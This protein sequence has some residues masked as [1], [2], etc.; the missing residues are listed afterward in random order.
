[1]KSTN[2][3]SSGPAEWMERRAGAEGNPSGPSPRRTQKRGRVSPA[4]ERIRPAAKRNPKQKLVSRWPPITV[5][6]RQAAY[7]SL[8]RQAASGVDGVTG[9]RYANGRKDRLADRPDRVL[10]G[11]YRA[12]PSRR[13]SIP[14]A[15]GST[16]PLGIAAREDQLVQQARTDVILAPIY[17]SVFL[18]F[19]YGFRPQRSAHTAWD[20]WSVGLTRRRVNWIGDADIRGFLDAVHRDG[21]I[22]FLEH[23]IGDKR[24]IRRI[25]KGLHAGVM[26]GGSGADTGKGTPPGAM[27]SPVRANIY[28]HY[29]FDR[30][31]KGGRRTRAGGDVIGVR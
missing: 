10:S 19:S 7:L 1:M 2:K 24:V 30:W 15:D 14:K 27:G 28:L 26:E 8:K 20:A 12:L 29:V 4:V 9:G 6:A 13:V 31:T 3:G 11:A 16:R 22:R 5:D 23:G 17:E 25:I 21:G 18:G